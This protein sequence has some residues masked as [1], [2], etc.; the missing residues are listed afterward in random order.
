[1]LYEYRV[2]Y[3]YLGHYPEQSLVLSSVAHDESDEWLLAW[4]VTAE[5]ERMGKWSEELV[6]VSIKP[7][8][9]K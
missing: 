3:Y 9:R 5:L 4:D 7:N 2:V 8:K 6:M 1:M